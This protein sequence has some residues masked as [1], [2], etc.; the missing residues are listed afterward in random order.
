M[1]VSPLISAQAQSGD[2]N[3][4]ADQNAGAGVGREKKQLLSPS[5]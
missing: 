1:K 4:G 5:G 3:Q 2:T